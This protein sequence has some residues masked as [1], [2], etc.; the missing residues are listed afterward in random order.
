MNNTATS[1]LIESSLLQKIISVLK[2]LSL[3]LIDGDR[4]IV[5][6]MLPDWAEKEF[7]CLT[8]TNVPFE[9]D[10]FSPFLE[11]FLIDAHIFWQER[12]ARFLRSGIWTEIGRTGQEI[13]LEAIALLINQRRIVLIEASETIGTEKFEWLQKARQEQLNIIS[14]R[15]IAETKLL[16]VTLYDNLTGLPN[17]AFFLSQL[18]TY[19]ETYFEQS[20]R[21]KPCHFAI[22]LFN[23][24]RFNQLNCRYNS[25]FGDQVL[26]TVANQIRCCL[27]KDDVPVRFGADEFGLLLAN[28]VNQED[29]LSVVQQLQ[30]KICQS[31]A[32][33]QH[34]IELSAGFGIAIIDNDYRSARDLLRDAST[35]MHEAKALGL[36][37]CAFFNRSMRIRALEL[38]SLEVELRQAIELEQLEIWFQPIISLETSTINGFEALLRWQHPTR[39]WISPAK[40]IPLAE[41]A[42]LIYDID[43]WVFKTVCQLVHTWYQSTA[44]KTC[45]NINI[46]ALDFADEH[47][48]ATLEAILLETK[49]DPN[50]IRLEITETEV[51]TDASLAVKTL[52]GLK[53]LG[54]EVAIDDFGMGHASFNYLQELPVDK[55]KIDGY[56]TEAMLSNGGD[57]MGTMINLAHRLGMKVTVEQVET[58]EQADLLKQLG[59]DTAQGYLFSK[60]LT[61]AEASKWL[62]M[63]LP[64]DEPKN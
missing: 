52:N 43:K 29:V 51:L 61:A 15:K 38:W 8:D 33:D 60:P 10:L 47:L 24:D 58:I 14:E 64:I 4:F 53:K 7:D 23:L 18:E 2:I 19:F 50:Q 28:V 5:L 32:I 36:N 37:K 41:K 48:L 11:N 46:S 56:F 45:V 9:A 1:S 54:L 59:C 26:V 55:L 40:F 16:S 49:V 57:I 27:R 22:V 12:S 63:K 42:G 6:G 17:R 44:Q 35:A 25:A 62:N 39:G 31:F 13:K 30:Q 34:R 21:S 3:E 20:Q